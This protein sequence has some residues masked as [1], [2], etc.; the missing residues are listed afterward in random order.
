MHWLQWGR[1]FVDFGTDHFPNHIDMS[2]SDIGLAIYIF[3][4]SYII[5][6]RA[7]NEEL[8]PGILLWKTRFTMDIRTQTTINFYHHAELTL[9]LHTISQLSR[10]ECRDD[11]ES[12]VGKL[13]CYWCQMW[14][15]TGVLQ[16]PPRQ[17]V[18]IARI[19]CASSAALSSTIVRLRE[20]LNLMIPYT[21]GL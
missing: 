5:R 10:D 9:P 19:V 1:R 17:I 4:G 18:L 11:I 6:T 7:P 8:L 3:L 12:S 16:T 2:L 21:S 14:K 15:T 13:S 20:G